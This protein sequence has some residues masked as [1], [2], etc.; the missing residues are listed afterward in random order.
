MNLEKL[1]KMFELTSEV[2][3]RHNHN[4]SH[5]ND[6]EIIQR[7]NNELWNA[8]YETWVRVQ[9]NSKPYL[10]VRPRLDR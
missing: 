10:S 6:A 3:L 8:G 4:D 2:L 9:E 5:E 1:N 7:L